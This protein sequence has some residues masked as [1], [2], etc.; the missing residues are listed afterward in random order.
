MTIEAIY[1]LAISLGIQNDLRGAAAVRKK[2][3]RE[4]ML[5]DQLTREQKSE[6]DRERLTNPFSD[7]RMYVRDPKTPVRRV[8]AGIDIEAEEVL[9]AHE[10]SRE[11]P[12]D[13][14]IA[15][16]PVGSA[17]AGLHEVMEL[18]AEVLAQY[19]VPITIAESLIKL[20]LDEVE[21]SISAVNHYKTVDAAALLKQDII[22]VHTAADNNL[23][24]YL[25]RLLKRESRNIERVGDVMKLLKQIP[26]YRA[27]IRLKAGPM[28][29]TGTP[30]RYTGKIALT[31]ITGGTEGSKDMYERM[32]QAGIGT[33]IGMH[34]Q[35]EHKKEAEK[36]HINVII[37][38]H[39][40]SDSVGMNFFL[41]EIEKRG[42]EVIPCS[43]LIRVK[44]FK[45]RRRS[46]LKRR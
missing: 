9:L 20:R 36:H 22:C 28:L 29:F 1:Q 41:D 42:V 25:H 2:L 45:D 13:L 18:Q 17:L 15:H 39:I 16:H 34:M 37:A 23:A 19:G 38:G 30:E 4:R 32:A 10:L 8:L 6:Y 3:K 43:G 44:R 31:E 21:R 7:T 26:E 12:I 14:I 35:E 40:S 11:K 46:A 33:I 5:Y 24:N 27:A